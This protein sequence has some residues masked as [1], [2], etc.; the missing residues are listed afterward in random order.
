MKIFRVI[1]ITKKKEVIRS[2][3]MLFITYKFTYMT[4][5]TCYNFVL[6]QISFIEQF[7]YLLKFTE[8]KNSLRS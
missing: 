6:L 5:K 1:R 3:V 2:I 7:K 8:H 4:K